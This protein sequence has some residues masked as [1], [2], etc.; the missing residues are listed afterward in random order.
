MFKGILFA[1]GYYLISLFGNQNY[2]YSETDCGKWFASEICNLEKVAS[3]FL[4]PNIPLSRAI[5]HTGFVKSPGEEEQFEESTTCWLYEKLFNS[6]TVEP[7]LHTQN[8]SGTQCAS[9]TAKARDHDQI[10]GEYR[11]AAR[12]RWNINCKQ[13]FCSYSFP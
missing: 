9:G 10:T 1:V 7:A 13:K 12:S 2:S 11:G 3:E 5:D 4:K 6:D 8:A